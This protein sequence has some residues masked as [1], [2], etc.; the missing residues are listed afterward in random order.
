MDRKEKG[1]TERLKEAVKQ[2]NV[3]RIRVYRDDET[4]LNIPVN[5]GVLGGI[6]GIATIPWALII[7]AIAGIGLG[8]KIE[9]VK[10]DGSSEWEV[11][12]QDDISDGR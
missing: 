9:I 8:C 11:V 6:V 12:D 10:K 5:V 1:V 7:G 3:D 4:I 2:G